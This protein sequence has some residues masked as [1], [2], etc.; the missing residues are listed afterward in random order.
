MEPFKV[1]FTSNI[2][3]ALL[4]K[5]KIIESGK[6]ISSKSYQLFPKFRVICRFSKP[7]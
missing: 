2:G 1:F 7:V 6:A 3:A 5:Y 4:P